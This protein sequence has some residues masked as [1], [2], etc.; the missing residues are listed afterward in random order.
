[1]IFIHGGAFVGGTLAPYDE[2]LK[3]LVDKFAVKV[4]SIDYR[5]LPEKR[6]SRTVQRLL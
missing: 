4:I 1:M 5:L 3:M 6:L 2:S